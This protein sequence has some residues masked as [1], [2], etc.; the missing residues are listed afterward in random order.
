MSYDLR[1]YSSG[2][3]DAATLRGL[4]ASSWGLSI[5]SGADLESM[6]MFLPVDRRGEYA[7][8][9]D[10]PLDEDPDDVPTS[11]IGLSHSYDVSVEGS[12]HKAIPAAWRFAKKLAKASSGVA[13]DRQ[14]DECW[15]RQ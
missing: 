15:P 5:A 3:L 13:V 8:T 10:G 4:V 7:F 1:V 14:T 2:V 6:P 9:V 11:A 12:K